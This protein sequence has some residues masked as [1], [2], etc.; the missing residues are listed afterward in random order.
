MVQLATYLVVYHVREV[1]QDVVELLADHLDDLALV[2]D[3]VKRVSH[4]VGDGR[5]NQREQ[6]ALGSGGVVEDFLRDVDEADHELFILTLG[7]L[8][9]TLLNLKKLELRD[10]LI[11]N[12]LH[13]LEPSDNNID[14]FMVPYHFSDVIL[15]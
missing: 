6:L 15:G 11:I 14:V 13:G 8:N 9:L 10:V 5:V 1:F 3:A 4:L 2:D 12:T 7:S